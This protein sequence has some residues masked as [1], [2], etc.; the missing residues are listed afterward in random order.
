MKL[1]PEEQKQQEFYRD[2][3]FTNQY[4]T[5]WKNVGACAFCE[6]R[7]KYIFYEEN[8]IM[9][10]I[11]LFAYIDGHFL[12]VPRRHLRSVKEMTEIEWATV[13][14]C[15]YI[16][17]KLI[18]KVHN[19]SGMQTILKEGATAQ[20]TVGDHI[21]FHCVP[22]DAPDLSVWNYRKLKYTPLENVG[23]YKK[24]GKKI[25]EL[26]RKYD[27]KYGGGTAHERSP[28]HEL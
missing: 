26:S 9:M 13:R 28:A 22:F 11:S 3:R 21:H 5:V 14:K 12:I 8:G 16:A 2:A 4:D 10:T 27:D 6:P 24:Q 25:A 17:K 15:M 18:R 23:L 20:S 19:V 1:T 7:D